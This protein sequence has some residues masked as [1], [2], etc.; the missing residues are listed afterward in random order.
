MEQIYEI[1]KDKELVV[2]KKVTSIIEKMLR[3]NGNDFLHDRY[4]EIVYQEN[5]PVTEFEHKCKNL[6]DGFMYLLSNIKTTVTTKFLKRFFF[7]IYEEVLDEYYLTNIANMFFSLNEHPL[8]EKVVEIT[9]LVY[10]GLNKEFKLLI[11]FMF[12]SFILVRNDIPCVQVTRRNISDFEE[13][14]K[15]YN[16]ENCSEFLLNLLL[17]SKYLD[18]SYFENIKQLTLEDVI[19]FIKNK[20][21][22]IKR[23]FDVD[24]IILYGS[25]AKKINRIDSDIDLLVKFKEDIPYDIKKRSVERMKMYF[26]EFFRRFVDIEEMTTL[27]S[28][29]MLM[30]LSEYKIIF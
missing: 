3:H 22:Y 9:H 8:L 21:D 20:E 17:K 27:I 25:F 16:K 10:E 19:N 2:R 1:V 6:Y 14:L 11:A 30:E 18:K 23:E 12:L 15:Y 4:K 28:D 24:K 26:L 29:E 13:L 7:I 5:G